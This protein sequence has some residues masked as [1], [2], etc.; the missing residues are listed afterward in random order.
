MFVQKSARQ[1]EGEG[2][3]GKGEVAELRRRAAGTM[4]QP[5]AHYPYPPYPGMPGPSGAAAGGGAPFP[6]FGYPYPYMY[7]HPGMAQAKSNEPMKKKRGRPSKRKKRNKQAKAE[8][9]AS[10]HAPR[11]M[12]PLVRSRRAYAE[13]DP[14]ASRRKLVAQNAAPT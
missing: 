10:A 8:V 7:P 13:Q 2:C 3:W 9:C 1:G 4:W 12:R 11:N 14:A 5:P 6:N